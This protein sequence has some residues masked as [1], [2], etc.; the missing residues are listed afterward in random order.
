MRAECGPYVQ[1][2]KL[3]QQMAGRYQMDT[4]LA[5]APL[6]RHFMEEVEV[7]VAS[8]KFDHTGFM[9]NIR[10]PLKVTAETTT[11]P[12]RKEFLQAV[13]DALHERL[14]RP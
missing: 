2:G 6:L 11:E 1:M 7:N 14:Q 13:C 9:D 3:A 10:G 5:L 8:D 4:N 12:R